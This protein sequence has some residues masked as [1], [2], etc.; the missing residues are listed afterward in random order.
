MSTA[1][2]PDGPKTL[3]RLHQ[4]EDRLNELQKS[5]RKFY[6]NPLIVGLIVGISCVLVSLILANHLDNLNEDKPATAEILITDYEI[7]DVN[8]EQG[9]FEIGVPLQVENPMF[10]QRSFTIDQISISINVPDELRPELINISDYYKNRDWMESFAYSHGTP[11]T[12]KP[13]DVVEIDSR[14]AK[15]TFILTVPGE[16]RVKVR[17]DYFDSSSQRPPLYGYFDIHLSESGTIYTNNLEFP[18]KLEPFEDLG[19]P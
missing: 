10:S 3:E 9:L 6:N 11:V 14:N 2:N 19:G 16:Y 5:K 18:I 8:R 17:V 7:F 4:I 12:V 15:H 1:S 13:G